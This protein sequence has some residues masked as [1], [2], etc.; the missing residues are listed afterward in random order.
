MLLLVL[1]RTGVS[2]RNGRRSEK[3]G[4]SAAALCQAAMTWRV[5]HCAIVII[6]VGRCVIVVVVVVIRDGRGGGGGSGLLS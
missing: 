4:G 5:P 1:H 6:I 2:G 3:A